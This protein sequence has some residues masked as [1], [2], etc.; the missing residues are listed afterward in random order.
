MNEVAVI[1][2]VVVGAV[3]VIGVV[4]S[5]SG[6]IG[7]AAPIVLVV[8]GVGLGAIPGADR[9]DLAPEFI[10][11][12]VIPPILYSAARNVPFV[13]FRRNFRVILFLSVALVVI[14]AVLVALLVS[15][16]WAGVG[17]ALALALGAVVAPPDAV[18][19]TSLARRLGLPPRIVTIL[20]GEGLLNDATA[21]VL[22]G[23]AL[24]LVGSTGVDDVN[25]GVIALLFLWAVVGAAVVG[26]LLGTFS[27]RLRQR[28]SDTV[29]DTAISL[30][31]PFLAYLAAEEV[32]ASG[33]VS[34]VA[35]GIVAG[36]SSPFR[37]AAPLRI[38]ETANWRLA[39]IVLENGV[40]LYMGMRLW[41]LVGDVVA[42]PLTLVE[43]I[44]LGMLVT[45]VLVAVRFAVI[46]G[47]LW[48]IRRRVTRTQARH[49]QVGERLREVE[50]QHRAAPASARPPRRRLARF[51]VWQEITGNDLE[52]ERAQ[53]LAWRDGVILGMAG[54]RGVITVAAVQT[55]PEDDGYRTGLV[56]VANFVAVTTLLVQ[57]LTLPFVVTRLRP[58]REE[59][60]DQRSEIAELRR[61][62][63]D[64]GFDELERIEKKRGAALD[65]TVVQ[66]LRTAG[67]ARSERVTRWGEGD[68]GDP[69]SSAHQFEQLRAKTL[70]AQRSALRHERARGAYSSEAVAF[71]GRTLDAEEFQL[72][73]FGGETLD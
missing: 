5:V 37:V 43:V 22:L 26:F 30:A 62:V 56:L 60:A 8:V 52:A 32:G 25:G 64:A 67:E 47:V 54:M 51:R 19:A 31:V 66:A 13:D 55:L 36:N 72:R 68:P 57:G 6:R 23:T 61:K 71:V 14:S 69:S 7:V 27:V 10:L 16:V 15:L 58:A 63:L 40:F 21:L 9:I 18:A 38:T 39:T 29:L 35:A 4:S 11:T 53:P 2:L 44:G 20:E 70:A 50:E 3:L 48:S 1:T 46:P 33:I 24:S 12:V 45:A 41:P 42:G 49:E 28:V 34:V 65:P 59:E 73:L 17:L